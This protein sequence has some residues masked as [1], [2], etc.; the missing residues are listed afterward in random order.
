MMIHNYYASVSNAL[1]V[2]LAL[3]GIPTMYKFI[4]ICFFIHEKGFH[5]IYYFPIDCT[6]YRGIL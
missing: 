5:K 4:A 2:D 1:A 3:N 6:M